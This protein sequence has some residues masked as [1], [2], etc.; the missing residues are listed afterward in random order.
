[1]HIYK[2]STFDMACEQFDLVAV[3]K[4]AHDGLKIIAVSDA[5][6]GLHNAGGPDLHRHGG[7]CLKNWRRA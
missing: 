6:G 4:M 2:H 1:M 5:N 7:S 3:Q